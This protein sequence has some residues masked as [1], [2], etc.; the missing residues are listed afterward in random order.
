[1]HL[2]GK[3]NTRIAG[4][5]LFG[6]GGDGS[7]DPPSHESFP[8]IHHRASYEYIISIRTVNLYRRRVRLQ[9]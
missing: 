9:P 8:W 5:G 1:M 3:W 7:F 6:G 2:Y 4:N